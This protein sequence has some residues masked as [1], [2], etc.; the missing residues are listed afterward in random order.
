MTKI[1]ALSREKFEEQVQKNSE[2]MGRFFAQLYQRY[3]AVVNH[4]EFVELVKMYRRGHTKSPKYSSMHARIFG[5]TKAPSEV[6]D[7]AV[8]FHAN[9]HNVM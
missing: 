7:F 4:P 5:A 9:A 1:D 3:E 2:R 8:E 6:I